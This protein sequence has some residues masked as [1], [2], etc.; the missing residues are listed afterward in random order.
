MTLRADSYS[1][2][3][4]VQVFVQHILDGQPSFN[5]TT[6]PTLLQVEK[7]VDRASGVLNVALSSHG[8]QAAAIVANSTAKL[9]CDD[10]VTARVSEHVEL[11]RRGV[12]YSEVEGM[13]T[14]G[15]RNIHKAAQAFTDE[16]THGLV[17]LG[18]PQSHRESDGLAFTGMDDQ[19]IRADHDDASLEQPMFS[20]E[21]FDNKFSAQYGYDDEEV[22]RQ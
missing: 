18:I 16:V 13:R 20:R 6:V 8:F 12:G 4:E 3:A 21:L 22:G 7:L 1:S 14:Y 15:F 10:W 11:T 2:A 5:S 9:I 19:G 17:H